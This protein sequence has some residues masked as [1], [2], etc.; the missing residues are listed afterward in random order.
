MVKKF[1]NK[2]ET[3]CI[4]VIRDDDGHLLNEENNVK[5]RW[6]SYFEGV[7][8]F[9]DTLADDNVTATEYMIDDGNEREITMNE[10]I[11]GLKRTKVR[12][13][14]AFPTSAPLTKLVAT[15]KP[16]VPTL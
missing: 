11:K 9:E 1:L 16:A 8:A 7:F 13:A 14:T 3:S 4:H 10:I 5:E 12:K 2:S 6:K 15:G